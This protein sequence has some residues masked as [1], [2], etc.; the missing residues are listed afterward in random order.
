MSRGVFIAGTD[1][2]VGKTRVTVALLRCLQQRSI[3]AAGMK[4]VATGTIAPG[5]GSS[6]LAGAAD[7]R[8]INEDVA[9]IAAHC[10][11]GLQR[12]L[13]NPYCF[14]PPV[15]PHIAARAAGITIDPRR[16]AAAFEALS[17]RCAAVVV[18]GT[19]GWLAPI[20][21]H[22]TMAD[23]AGALGLPV[24]LVVGV[25]LGCLNH[26]LLTE[27]AIRA[28]GLALAGWIGSVL[29]PDM[30]SLEDNLATL[31]ARLGAPRLA[32]LPHCP[33]TEGDAAAVAAASR[34]LFEVT[35]AAAHAPHAPH[36]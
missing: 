6:G 33:A 13:I 9:A 22:A 14:D 36:S 4:P 26:A 12:A 23:I 24:V 35:P 20:G 31:A 32:L 18:E 2:G 29:D 17:R 30:I 16:V 19:G 7:T 3:E 28:S 15:S 11:P 10:V 34:L 1:T 27:R 8:R 5:P 25:R 21:E